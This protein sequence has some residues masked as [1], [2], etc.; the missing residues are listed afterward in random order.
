M[1]I[2]LTRRTVPMFIGI[3]FGLF[4]VL[5]CSTFKNTGI[6]NAEESYNSGDYADA[7]ENI[8]QQIRNNPED[9]EAFILKLKILNK[10]ATGTNPVKDRA[11][12]FREMTETAGML[13]INEAEHPYTEKADSILHQAWNKEQQAGIK[14]LQQDQSH[15]YQENFNEIVNH[16]RNALILK[17]ENETTYNLLATTYYR[18]G[19]IDKAIKTIDEAS[20]YITVLSNE[21]NSK[22]AY[23]NLESGNIAEAI[24][25][26]QRLLDSDPDNKNYQHGLVNS[27]ILGHHHEESISVLEKMMKEGVDDNL[28]KEA[29]AS[30]LLFKFN[31]ELENSLSDDTVM[32][33]DISVSQLTD[34]YNRVEKLNSERNPRQEADF[35]SNYTIAGLYNNSAKNLFQL[36]GR[37][38][39]EN[40]S[41]AEKLEV[42]GKNFLQSSLPYW[43][44]LANEYPDNPDIIKS[45][46]QVYV[47]LEMK[48]NAESIRSNYNF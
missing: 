18:H 15:V 1:I 27:Y 48:E 35:G 39:S 7:R 46:Y 5:S 41:K 21:L 32:A 3:A 22:L 30:E 34:I 2:T 16:F 38:S 43:E 24:E 14:L 44:K 37:I 40:S 20:G 12:V 45:L 31:E 13:K 23:L 36:A 33:G 47:K 4:F 42:L 10:L 11:P 17:P 29:L 28:Y 19:D 26:Y 8:D 25:I 6:N 9:S